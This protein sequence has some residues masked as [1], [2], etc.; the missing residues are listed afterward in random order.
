[1]GKAHFTIR[2]VLGRN[3]ARTGM[4]L[5]A[6]LFFIVLIVGTASLSI[7]IEDRYHRADAAYRLY[8]VHHPLKPG[9]KP[10]RVDWL[11]GRIWR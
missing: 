4:R 3:N 1:M 5:Y 6:A 9:E 11:T 7:W 8:L 10:P 2:R